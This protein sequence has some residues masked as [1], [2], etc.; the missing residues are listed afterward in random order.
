[1]AA[2]DPESKQI[3]RTQT[4]QCISS[5]YQKEVSNE[6]NISEHDLVNFSQPT[7]LENPKDW[8]VIRKWIITYVLCATGFNRILVSTIMAPALP[9]IGTELH[10]ETLEALMSMSVYL[11]AT[12]VAPLV[13]AP[14]SEIY[15]RKPILHITN[16]W[17]LAWNLVCGFARNKQLLTAARAL[18]GLGAGAAYMLSGR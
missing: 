12:A 8:S 16:I 13:V 11:L 2:Q 6:S 7:D 10:M 14:L 17:F 9:V 3:I 1:M 5:P 15:G 4:L 18:A